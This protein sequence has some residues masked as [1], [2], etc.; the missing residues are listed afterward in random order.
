MRQVEKKHM[1][2]QIVKLMRL[3]YIENED[4]QEDKKDIEYKQLIQ[5]LILQENQVQLERMKE[6]DF[7]RLYNFDTLYSYKL[8]DFDEQQQLAQEVKNE[9]ISG[10][11]DPKMAVEY[12]RTAREMLRRGLLLN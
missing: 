8:D 1:K 3:S 7:A 12:E 6:L 10:K 9:Y 11:F 2:E 5:Q 4:T